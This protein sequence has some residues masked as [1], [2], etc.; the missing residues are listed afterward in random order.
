MRRQR[1]AMLSRKMPRSTRAMMRPSGSAGFPPE[2]EREMLRERE[3]EREREKEREKE[4]ERLRERKRE[5]ERERPH[6]CTRCS[7]L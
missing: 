2:R 4:R 3:R 6:H 1:V 7:S 5:I